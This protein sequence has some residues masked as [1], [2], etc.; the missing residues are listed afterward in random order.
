M[1]PAGRRAAPP[2]GR[3]SGRESGRESGPVPGL[4]SGAGPARVP[5]P[6]TLLLILVILVPIEFGFY[7]GPLFFT[8]SKLYLIVVTF[9]ILPRLGG[10]KLRLYDWMFIGHVLWSATAFAL[11]YGGATALE[12]SGTYVLEFLVVYLAVRIWITRLD[13]ALALIGVLFVM[14]LVAA[15]AALPEAVLRTQYIPDFATSITGT[16]YRRD[17]E[18]RMGIMR[19]ASFFEHPILHGVFCSALLSLVW[20]TSSVPQ[21]LV[22]VPVIGLGTFLSASSAPLLILILQFLLLG[23]ERISRGLKRRATIFGGLGLGA[24]VFLETF[25]G[26]GAVGF[27]AALTLNPGT[28]YTRRNQWTFGIDD[29][30]ANPFFGID[31]T[32]W[33]R[34]FWLAGSVDNYWL[35]MMMR[36]GIPSLLFLAAAVALIWLAL[37]RRDTANPQFA[38]L[39]TGWGLMMVALI[40]GGAT[41]A[42]FGKLQPLFAFYTG[43]G[44]ALA[45]CLLPQEGRRPEAAAAEMAAGPAADRRGPRY[46]RFPP[47]HRRGADRMG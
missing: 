22:R 40:L 12:R 43:F 25:S 11:I 18:V 19:A 28:A 1:P 36:S 16:R 38:Q 23:L 35:L 17:D 2:A 27:L 30:L 3:G 47:R 7:A 13:Q 10:L 9:L 41:V 44:A 4:V 34:P 20:F 33:T 8:W 21:R 31:P 24:V 45:N 26:R 32:T 5:L 6:L 15:L 29:V 42:Y 46:S 14:V 39:R 37:A